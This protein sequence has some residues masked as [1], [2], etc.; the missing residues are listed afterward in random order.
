MNAN[1][2]NGDANPFAADPTSFAPT[3]VPGTQAAG[4]DKKTAP[5][6]S[7][8]RSAEPQPEAKQATAADKPKDGKLGKPGSRLRIPS[9][10]DF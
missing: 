7:L 5:K 3:P 10:S 6:V 1:P 9:M 4:Q 2:Q 8:R